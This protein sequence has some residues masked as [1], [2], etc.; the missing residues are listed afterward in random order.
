MNTS[1]K[2]TVS[3]VNNSANADRRGATLVGIFFIFASATS[4]HPS[5]GP[6]QSKV[7]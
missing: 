4:A 6:E 5:A 3:Q 1:K 2:S 7:A